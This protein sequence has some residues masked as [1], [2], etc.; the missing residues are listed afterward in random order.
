MSSSA[1][2]FS[3]R[4]P[5]ENTLPRSA[6]YNHLPDLVKTE[7]SSPGLRRTF[8]DTTFPTE[9][10]SPSKEDVAAGKD[11]LRRTSIRSKNKPTVS[12]SRFTVSSEELD[13]AAKAE[14]KDA[15]VKIPETKAPEPVAR[16]SKTRAM[17]GRLV[18]LAR[19]P[20]I[21]S[22]PT[23]PP[24]PSAK[25][26]RLRMLRADDQSQSGPPSPSPSKT[27]FQSD[28]GGDSDGMPPS[29][30]R[31]ILNKRPRRP[32]VAV[33]AQ[34]RSDSPSTPSS[35][36]SYSL[37]TKHSFE[38][39][40]SSLN[41]STPVLPPMPRGAAATAAAHSGHVEPPR[42]KDEL[43]AV[44]RGLEA[45]YQKFQSKSS[46][47]K[48]NVIRSSLL[49]FLNRHQ[50]HPSHKSLKPED[51][52]R[53]IN[54][55]NKWWTGLLEMLNGRN[56]QSIS[57]TDRPVYLEAI[58]GIMMRPEW[59]IPYPA[60]Q[61]NGSIPKPLHHASTSISESSDGS[62][63]SDFLIESI[64]HNIRNVFTQNLLSQMAFVVERMS[65]RHAPASLV[66]FCGKA[67]AYAFFFCQGV[68][69][70]LVRLW[71]TP[72]NI[73]RRVLAESDVDRSSNARSLAQDLALNFPM[74]LRPLS[75][76]SHAPLVRYLRQK[77]DVPLNTSQISWQG[78]WVSRWCGRD[79]DLFF[80]FVKYVHVLYAD[81]LPR[82]TEK[83]KRILAPGLLPI[84]SQLLVVLEDT[85][86]KQSIPQMPESTHTPAAVTF[87][88]FIEGADAVSALPLGAANSHRSMAE[89]RLIILLRDFL[90]ESSVEPNHARLLYAESFCSIMKTAAQ[91]TSLFDHNA[92]FL[93]CDF[94]E[95]VIP[96][97]TRYSQANEMELFD[98]KFWLEACRQMMNSQNSLTEVRVFSF[99]FGIWN[100]WVASEDRKADLCLGFLLHEPTFY[101]YFSHWSPMVRAYFQRLLCWRVGRFNSEPSPLDSKIYETLLNRLQRLWTYYLAFQTKAEQEL[102]APLSSAPCTPA[103]GRRIII[104]RCD[105][106][107]SPTN[108]FVSFDRVVPP[109]PPEQP[110]TS[111]SSSSVKSDSS[112]E[113]Q[114]PPKKRWNILRAMFGAASSS[115]SGGGAASSSSS[116]E[117]DTN[118]SDATVNTEKC[119]DGHG[120]PSNA[121]GELLRPKTPHQAF[122]FRFSLE[123]TDRQWPSKNKRLFTP[124]LPVGAQLHV[125]LRNSASKTAGQDTTSESETDTILEGDAGS[126]NAP[127]TSSVDEQKA[128][129]A[130]SRQTHRSMPSQDLRKALSDKVAA[131]KYAGRSLA[132][133]AQIVS[134]CDSF[135]ARRRDEGVPCDRMVETPTLGVE[136]FR[137]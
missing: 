30:K 40:T 122:S 128:P 123:W 101:H 13:N 88:D 132:E 55:L 12:V 86:Y 108:L 80:V 22:S 133:W 20:W 106:P 67:C 121:S 72:A 71:N 135:F 118:G 68:A 47:L 39:F 89:N 79:T 59:R 23:Q 115:K 116:D 60:W 6:S 137:K 38:R 4:T 61:P 99:L 65:M 24:S 110:T 83:G 84:H 43:W 77:P 7:P 37:K 57:G 51:L 100:T 97:I 134:E 5:D 46:A 92:C 70:I 98:W 136:S 41:V 85:L 45:D 129:T 42:R 10:K 31:T 15:T 58:A 34:G 29:R 130:A 104:I 74:A 102:T 52:D 93:L 125:Q 48:A 126:D 94:I 127:E 54:I 131:S 21:S 9:S 26:A 50:L 69:D 87:D 8:S 19:K 96:I 16:P 90:S 113:S 11:I 114:P 95:E 49:P 44:F 33:V 75:F 64:H 62:S 14:S 25:S 111:K 109:A 66:A 35:P 36:S 28:S 107:L 17:S 63:G 53:R 2:V 120:Q 124:C 32:M 27:S 18:N 82:G 117:S 56:N 91:R 112:T 73:Y 1:E 103:P 3:N 78:P 81:S 76:H 119:L 105:S